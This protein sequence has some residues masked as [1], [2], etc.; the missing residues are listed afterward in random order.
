[1]VYYENFFLG[2]GVPKSGGASFYLQCLEDVTTKILSWDEFFNLV[3]SIV[4]DGESLNTGP[5]NG[6]CAKLKKERQLSQCCLPLFSIWCVAHRINLAWKTVAKIDVVASVIALARNFSTYFHKSA[7]R[8]KKLDDIAASNNLKEPLRYP[9]YFEVRWVEFLFNLFTAVLRNWRAAIKYFE[10]EGLN[11]SLNRWLLYDRIHIL[12][13]LA[14]ILN[15]IKTYQKICQSD[16]ICMLDL[17]HIKNRLIE[18]LETCENSYVLGGWEEL[19]L[20]KLVK[21]NTST[22]FYGHKL[23]SVRTDVRTIRSGNVFTKYKRIKIVR[24]LIQQLKL[25]FGVDTSIQEAITPLVKIS[26]SVTVGQI[27]L[28]HSFLIPD[29]DEQSFF[30]HYY[31][32]ADLLQHFENVTALGTLKILIERA[33]EL[34]TIIYAY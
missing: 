13:F 19:F 32:A 17:I 10:S 14:D 25:R 6:V 11:V 26:S 33:P 20:K 18:R 23:K 27:K 34:N 7:K 1:M 24:S 15:I 2:F 30:S 3:T 22:Y 28:C 5:L 4:T 31:I 16:S 29:L 9:K 12:T 8:T 21:N